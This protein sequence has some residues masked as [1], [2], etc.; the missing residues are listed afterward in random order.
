MKAKIRKLL[1]FV[2]ETRFEMDRAVS[3]R[4]FFVR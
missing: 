2:E 1:T 3:P 4:R